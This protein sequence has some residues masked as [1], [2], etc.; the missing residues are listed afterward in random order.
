VASRVEHELRQARRFQAEG[1]AGRARVC[2]RRA[3]GWSVGPT[4]RRLTGAE[5]PSSAM[6]LLQWYASH[7]DTPDPLRQAARRLTVHVTQE[8]ALPHPEDPIAD[9]QTLIDALRPPET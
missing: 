9:A 1:R 4:Y 6:S 3:A 2:A 8:H 5:P 7:P